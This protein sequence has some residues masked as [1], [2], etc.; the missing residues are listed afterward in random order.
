MAQ[1]RDLMLGRGDV[2]KKRHPM[3]E[4]S[5]V[6]DRHE[7]QIEL[8]LAAVRAHRRGLRLER[9]LLEYVMQHRLEDGMMP[10]HD[11]EDHRRLS[12]DV[13]AAPPVDR[14]EPVI[15]ECDARSDRLDSR[16]HDGDALA[17]DMDGR[18]EEPQLLALHP[19][20]SELSL[21]PFRRLDV[22]VQ[23]V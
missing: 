23:A 3:R 22:V 6:L 11:A 14:A 21:Q 19:L 5:A 12:D 9:P 16:S 15:H 10:L 2:A 7:L 20:R 17:R 18:A 8:E 1:R 4:L 13:F